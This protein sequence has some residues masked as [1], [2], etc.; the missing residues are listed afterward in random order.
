MFP[1]WLMPW[2]I[3]FMYLLAI[4]V[5]SL[6]RCLFKSLAHFVT[7]WSS[8]YS[9]H[10]PG[11]FWWPQT[12]WVLYVVRMALIPPRKRALSPLILLSPSIPCPGIMGMS[13]ESVSLSC[14]K[15]K[16]LEQIDTLSGS[17]RTE[18]WASILFISLL[19]DTREIESIWST[20][21][22]WEKLWCQR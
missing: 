12:L 20:W 3:F 5:S 1:W 11:G 10:F 7:G 6:E 13:S 9:D 8:P 17:A 4:Y 16:W 14:S 19:I 2:S 22:P 15:E 21:G 18:I